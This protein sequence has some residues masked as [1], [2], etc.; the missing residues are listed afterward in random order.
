LAD[1]ANVDAGG[2]SI[3][4]PH[5]NFWEA[6][7]KTPEISGFSFGDLFFFLLAITVVCDSRVCN[8]IPR[9]LRHMLITGSKTE[10]SVFRF[11][12][13]FSVFIGFYNTDVGIGIGFLKYR[14]NGSVFGI[15]TM[16]IVHGTVIL[17]RYKIHTILY[18][19]L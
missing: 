5:E 19:S 16:T 6:Y 15:P 7:P 9:N 12:L 17:T 10:K 3:L 1:L 4:P 14:D 11:F 8:V 18:L 2:E 13:R